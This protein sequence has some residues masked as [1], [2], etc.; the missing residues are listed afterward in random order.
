MR[1]S[2]LALFIALPAAVYA[3]ASPQQNP[4]HSDAD[5]I[6][7]GSECIYDDSSCC[8]DYQCALVPR[9]GYVC[10]ITHLFLFTLSAEL[11]TDLRLNLST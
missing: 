1:L 10:H 8:E 2:V 9:V 5:C 3:A 11:N 7:F 6:P 4:R